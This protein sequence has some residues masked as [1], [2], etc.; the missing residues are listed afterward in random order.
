MSLIRVRSFN[1]ELSIVIPRRV[2][3]SNLKSHFLCGV[4]DVFNKMTQ[5]GY[6]NPTKLDNKMRVKKH[7]VK[8]F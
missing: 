2:L 6:D 8:Y 4:S 1:M 3:E 7:T 5:H